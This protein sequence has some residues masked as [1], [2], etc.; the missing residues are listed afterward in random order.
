MKGCS[1]RIAIGAD[2][3]GFYLKEFLKEKLSEI[4]W[5]DVGCF[6]TE[7]CDYP[8]F[9]RLVVQA[10]REK[11]VDYG[12]VLCGTGIGMSIAANRYSGVYAGLVWHEDVARRA[13]EEDNVN[14]LVLPSDYLAPDQAMACVQSWI[15]AGF[16]EGH[17]RERLK[18]I[19]SD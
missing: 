9:A 13:K 18:Q 19:D 14:V 12:I 16:K 7:T 10:V 15:N 6:S 1:M 2:H 5:E 17:Y 4:V 3:R 11:R 8:L